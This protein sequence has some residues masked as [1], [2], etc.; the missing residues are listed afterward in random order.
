MADTAPL[1]D[2]RHCLFQFFKGA[3]GDKDGC[4]SRRHGKRDTLTDPLP[5]TR[6][7]CYFAGK[8]RHIV[9]IRNF[10]NLF[11]CFLRMALTNCYTKR[12]MR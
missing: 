9:L 3:S 8:L 1:G 2:H 12:Q 6:D 11:D 10:R 7:Q 4:A 5:R